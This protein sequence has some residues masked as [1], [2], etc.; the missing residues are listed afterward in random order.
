MR[1]RSG[2]P[3]M[4]IW[5]A[6]ALCEAGGV[7]C[8]DPAG[9]F[10]APVAASLPTAW[11]AATHL[12]AWKKLL[13][14]IGGHSFGDLGKV[15][16]VIEDIRPE[17]VNWDKLCEAG[18]VGC[19][20]PAGGFAAPVAASL[21]TAWPAATHLPAWKKLLKRIGGHSFGDLGKVVAVI[22]DIRPENVNSVILETNNYCIL[23]TKTETILKI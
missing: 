20:D 21:P 1:D 23:S 22:E 18:G 4:R 10:A 16:A 17:N 19:A 8:A 2:A 9:G 7:G 5:P 11:P 13:K 14:R 12:P 3:G 15:V 6:V